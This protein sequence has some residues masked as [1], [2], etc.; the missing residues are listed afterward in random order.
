MAITSYSSHCQYAGEP[1]IFFRNLHAWSVR[2]R[3]CTTSGCFNMPALI[4]WPP[5]VLPFVMRNAMLASDCICFRSAAYW[6]QNKYSIFFAKCP[7][8][9]RSLY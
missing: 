6:A 3:L 1:R 7:S 8:T 9:F 5:S 4:L 2:T